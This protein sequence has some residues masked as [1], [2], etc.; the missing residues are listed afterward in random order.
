MKVYSISRWGFRAICFLILILPVSRH[1]KL[2]STGSKTQG[3]VTQLATRTKVVMG[4]ETESGFASEIE[5]KVDGHNYLAYGPLNFEYTP[6]HNIT[7]F[8]DRDDPSHN[9]IATFSG[10]YLSNYT[11]LPIILLVLWAAF[12]MSFNNYQRKQRFKKSKW[13]Q[14]AQNK[15]HRNAQ[16]LRRIP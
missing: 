4:K 3:T 8:Y 12:Y 7:V 10:F 1:W 5:F 13:Q 16:P 11:I 9:C 14:N 6:G 15:A 2:L